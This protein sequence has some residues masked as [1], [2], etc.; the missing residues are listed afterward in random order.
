VPEEAAKG[1]NVV[2]L[3]SGWDHVLALTKAGNVLVWASD[4]YLGS[5]N[6]AIPKLVQDGGAIAIAAGPAYSLA[7]L[8]D[9][10]VV[11]W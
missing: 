3:A 4:T 6:A 7:L 11:C 10:R 5:I 1:G 8:K 2:T 9:G